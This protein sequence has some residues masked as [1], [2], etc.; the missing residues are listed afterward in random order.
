[1]IY[2]SLR[3]IDAMHVRPDSLE[4]KEQGLLGLAWQTKVERKRRGTRFMV[5]RTGLRRAWLDVW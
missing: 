4:F 5:A 2:A 1:M 3:F